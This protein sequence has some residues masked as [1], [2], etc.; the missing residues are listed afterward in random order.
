MKRLRLKFN[1][2]AVGWILIVLGLLGLWQG[3]FGN[4]DASSLQNADAETDPKLAPVKTE[5]MI[6]NVLTVYDGDTLGCDLNRDGRIQKPQEQVR[7][8]GVD[9]PEMHYSRK[10]PTYG[11]TQPQDEPFAKEASK[12]LTQAVQGKTV[13]LE[14]D[15]RRSDKYERTLAYVFADAK[16][17]QSLNAQLLTQGYATVL[18]LGKNRRYEPQFQAAER[19]AQLEKQGLW[20]A[21]F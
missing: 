2:K 20:A 21:D 4:P 6:C 13:Y 9:S 1:E 14:F 18:F 17:Q 5:R 19:Q 16:S 3:R 10:N 12:W 8:L 11:S 7:L 15:E